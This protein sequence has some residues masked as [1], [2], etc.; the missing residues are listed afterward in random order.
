MISYFSWW[1]AVYFFYEVNECFALSHNYLI[2]ERFYL[3]R[4]GGLN[5]RMIV[6]AIV[7]SIR[8]LLA[9]TMYPHRHCHRIF[10]Y[11][12]CT[13]VAAFCYSY[14]VPINDIDSHYFGA[15]TDASTTF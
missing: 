1:L 13:L 4:Y 6:L 7:I 9:L 11:R 14:L 12:T 3:L 5:L 2:I 10:F 8:L 15:L